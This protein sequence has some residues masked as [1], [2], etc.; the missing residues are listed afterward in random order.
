MR[1]L[2]A[3]ILAGGHAGR[4]G[5]ASKPDLV[6]G[7]R[8]LLET[9]IAA[10]RSAGGERVVV[11]GPPELEAYGCPVVREDPPFGGPVAALAAGLA[12]LGSVGAG[13]DGAV[14]PA[15][16]VLVLACDMPGAVGAAARLVAARAA[17]P[18]SDGVCLVDVTG[19]AQWLAAVYS[20]AALA[21]AFDVL[22]GPTGDPAALDGAAMR[23]LAA[24]LDLTTVA[25]D[26]T[27]HD[28][29]TWSDLAEARRR[30]GGDTMADSQHP[31]ILDEWVAEAAAIAGID[32]ADVPIGTLLDL[33]RRAAH[34]VARPAAPVTTFVLG[35]AIGSGR[36]AD[37][38]T[39]L[40]DRL[41]ALAEQR[42][43]A[44]EGAAM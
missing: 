5:G 29:D 27:T 10:V 33:A 42:G 17:T 15:R 4:L 36:S 41:G 11:V 21:R 37:D 14:A 39:T 9:A 40:A 26:G 22:T 31:A 28:I 38:L 6:V 44:G 34:G 35:L 19:R 18:G 32:P 25:D 7:G 23:R 8:P 1:S 20:R 2:D 30:T 13:G 16:D 12:A 24:S 43:A 3:V